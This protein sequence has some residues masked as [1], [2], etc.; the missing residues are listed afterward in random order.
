[1]KK[2]DYFIDF[3]RFSCVANKITTKIIDYAKNVTLSFRGRL[4]PRKNVKTEVCS[5]PLGQMCEPEGLSWG[6]IGRIAK[7][8]E[9]FVYFFLDHPLINNKKVS[10]YDP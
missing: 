5:N 4:E 6:H 2:I 9:A 8:G 10:F 1:M 3:P 7:T